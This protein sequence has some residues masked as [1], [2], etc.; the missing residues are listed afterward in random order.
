[1]TSI[2]Y[3]AVAPTLVT[4]DGVIRRTLLHFWIST[5]REQIQLARD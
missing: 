1:M 3:T 2:L 5:L 4:I